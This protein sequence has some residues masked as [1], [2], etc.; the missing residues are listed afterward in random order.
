MLMESWIKAKGLL[1]SP[2]EQISFSAQKAKRNRRSGQITAY[3]CSRIQEKICCDTQ[4]SIEG[5]ALER[6]TLMTDE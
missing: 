1:Q 2:R 5:S 3:D 6:N 4:T